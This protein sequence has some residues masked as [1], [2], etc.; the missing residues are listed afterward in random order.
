MDADTYVESLAASTPRSFG[1]SAATRDEAEGWQR[2][3]RPA[4]SGLVGLEA[5]AARGTPPMDATLVRSEEEPDHVREEWTLET[6][7]GFH[8]PFY[9]L[10]PLGS[11]GPRPLVLTPHGHGKLGKRT[12]VGLS[13][14]EADRRDMQAGERDI[15]L[16]AVREGNIAIAPDMRGFAGLRRRE[17]IKRDANNSC[18][19]LQMHALLFGRTLIGE[20]VWDIQRL[21][22][23]AVLRDDVDPAAIAITGNSG[24]GTISVFAAAVDERIAVCVP[25]S[26][27]CT[28]RDSIGSVYHCECNYV[29]G[30]MQLGEMWDVAGLIAPRAFLAVSGR[31]DPLFPIEAVR[32]S[33]DQL[34]RIYAVF[35]ADAEC[36]LSIGEGGH[37]YYKR[38]VWPFIERAFAS[39]HVR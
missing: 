14:S 7:Q 4:L 28:F 26:Y 6:E 32:E 9:L 36:C 15:A 30:I 18:R 19:T 1:F 12:Y 24:G 31:A 23:W 10:R 29:P 34:R 33:Y 3:F 8:L 5:I 39:R 27:F 21:I 17:E 37:R 2:A 16:Q 11:S 38:D 20:R 13:E 35:D 25:S 22:D